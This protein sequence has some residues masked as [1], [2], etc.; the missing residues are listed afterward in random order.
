MDPDEARALGLIRT[1]IA[2]LPVGQPDDLVI[3][4]EPA[5]PFAPTTEPAQLGEGNVGRDP[6]ATEAKPEP[7]MQTSRPKD[8]SKPT[9][10]PGKAKSVGKEPGPRT[11]YKIKPGIDEDWRGASG[12]GRTWRDAL[13]R[14]FEKTGVDRSEFTIT[15][16]A[17]TKDGKSFPV[18][19][20]VLKGPNRGAEVSIDIGHKMHGPDAP[21]VG[22]QEAGKGAEAGHILLDDVPVNR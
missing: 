5:T 19:Y 14:A 8:P 13:A 15:K 6:T 10:T 7:P 4:E 17:P 2:F 11:P 16:T 3:K 21:H 22:W 18:E 1:A 12:A 20:T 9:G